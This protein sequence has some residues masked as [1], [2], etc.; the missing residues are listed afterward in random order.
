MKRPTY[1]HR[2]KEYALA[3]VLR[4]QGLGYR[5]ISKRVGI[6]HNT[7]RNWCRDIKVDKAKAIQ[8][9]RLEQF[10]FDR[11]K[12]NKSRKWRLV[13]ERGNR[14]DCCLN[15]SWMG[16]PINL[17]VHHIDG[18]RHNNTKPNISLLCLNCHSQTSNFR[19]SLK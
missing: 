3:R 8:L 16:K 15:T 9:S 14:C 1:K 5:T 11:L 17:E 13:L 4:E 12:N 19:R 18:N 7:I 2:D 6:N 10:E